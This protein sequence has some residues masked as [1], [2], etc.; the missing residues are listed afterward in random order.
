MSSGEAAGEHRGDAVL[1]DPAT[2]TRVVFRQRSGDTQGRVVVVEM[3]LQPEARPFPGHVHPHQ[4]ETI[5]V[6]HGTVEFRIGAREML[7]GPGCRVRVPAGVPHEFRN[8]GAEVAHVVCEL[9]PALGFEPLLEALFAPTA[10]AR[11]GGWRGLLERVAIA[12]AHFETARASFPPAAV[13]RPALRL[14]AALG[15]LL[16]YEG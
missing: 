5:D 10:S 7:A 13:Q 12:D 9:R 6:L 2:G 8:R 11:A 14:G 1:D 15:R 3:F 16:G 4:E